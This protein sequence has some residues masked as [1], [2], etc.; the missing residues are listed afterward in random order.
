MINMGFSMKKKINFYLI[1]EIV[2]GMA[3]LV[4]LVWKMYPVMCIAQYTHSTTD[5][6][7]MSFSV[8][9]VWES[10]HSLPGAIKEAFHTAVLAWKY[11]SGCFISMFVTALSP[12]AFD[13]K[14]YM[15]AAYATLIILFVSVAIIS[16][17]VMRNILKQSV[18]AVIAVACLTI[19]LLVNYL[20]SPGEGFYW[21]P[22]ASNYTI[23]F[24]VSLLTQAFTLLYMNTG[25]RAWRIVWLV[26]ASILAFILGQGNLLTALSGTCILFLELLYMAKKSGMKKNGV[27]IIFILSLISLMLSALAPGNYIRGAQTVGKLGFFATVWTSIKNGSI[28]FVSY[29]K[30]GTMPYYIFIAVMVLA[31]FLKSDCKFEFKKPLLFV[32]AA[33]LIYCASLAP[34]EFTGIPYY[35][36]V[37]DL[38]YFNSVIA[39]MACIVYVMGY[40]SVCIKRRL[41]VSSKNT[42]TSTKYQIALLAVSVSAG[43]AVIVFSMFN[44][45]NTTSFA[46]DV[47]LK[48]GDAVRFDKIIDERFAGYYD[49][50][51]RNMELTYAYSIPSV[52]FFN[53]ADTMGEKAFYIFGGTQI[54]A[55]YFYLQDENAVFE[56]LEYDCLLEKYFDKDTIIL[57]Q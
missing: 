33:Y 40:L 49:T 24:A 46:A 44:Y 10:T 50:G 18:A 53:D 25:R 15:Y 27:I 57:K 56:E 47:H 2:I 23:F 34:V 48:N 9:R 31:L 6:Y 41:E 4:W 3:F 55:D 8:H 17:V 16:Y 36:R 35:A 28:F 43:L 7:W 1:V 14:Y 5:D 12:V 22:G 26:I 42:L 30:N 11:H 37:L 45:L 39:T 13:E 54:A 38:I 51:T 29:H 52:F 21:W 19:F 20:P 32:A